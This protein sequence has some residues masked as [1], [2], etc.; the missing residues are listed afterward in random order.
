MAVAF[1]ELYRPTRAPNSRPYRINISSTRRW[2]GDI[3]TLT[4]TIQSA[5]SPL[6]QNGSKT[7]PGIAQEISLM[8]TFRMSTS[9]LSSSPIDWTIPNTFSSRDGV[10]Q[11]S[12]SQAFK[13]LSSKTFNLPRRASLLG[14]LVSEPSRDLP[15]AESFSPSQQGYAFVLLLISLSSHGIPS[16]QP[17][18]QNHGEHTT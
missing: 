13:K 9:P 11:E 1:W 3:L 17:L 2:A 14:H 5:T 7:S 8:A 18:V 15:G 10:P 12:P 16:V 6:V 4:L